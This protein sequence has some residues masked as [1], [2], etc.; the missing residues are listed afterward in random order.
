[1]SDA[2]KTIAKLKRY[3]SCSDRHQIIDCRD[4]AVLI[5]EIERLEDKVEACKY[6]EQLLRSG[7]K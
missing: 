6:R 4:I 5:A 2:E 7:N 1:M 3:A